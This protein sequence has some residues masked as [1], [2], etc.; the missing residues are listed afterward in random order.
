MAGSVHKFLAQKSF[1]VPNWV[2]GL[3]GLGAVYVL[4][5]GFPGTNSVGDE[6]CAPDE[7]PV[8]HDGHIDCVTAP[9]EGCG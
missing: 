9:P 5:Q 8:F 6:T 4:T 1:G 3:A 7:C 2:I